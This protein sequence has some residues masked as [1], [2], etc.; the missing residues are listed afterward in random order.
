MHLYTCHHLSETVLLISFGHEIS[1]PLHEQVMQAKSKIESNPFNGLIETV[2]AYNCLAVHYNPLQVAKKN[3]SN[4]ETVEQIINTILETGSP[5]FSQKKP[6]ILTIPVCYDESLG[7][8]LNELSE[9]LQ[10]SIE[11]IIHLHSRKIY[12]VF[13]T[14]FTPGFPYM[15]I[16][17][18]RLITKRKSSPRLKVEVG[19]VAIAG[20]QTGIYPFPTPGGWNIIG[21]TP[22][23]L[24]NRSKP[25][26]FF[27]KAGDQVRFTPITKEE[28]EQ[29]IDTT[30]IEKKEPINYSSLAT[31]KQEAAKQII[32]LEQCGFLTT[33]QDAGRNGHLQYGVPQTGAMD[34]YS[35]KLAN[36]LTGNQENT[37]VLEIT[38]S[39]HLFRIMKDCLVAF[40]GGGLQPI[41]DG[42]ELPLFE[43]LFI[44]EGT[45]IELKKQIPGFRLYMAVGGGFEAERFLGS[46]STD[47][48]ISAGGF[49]GRA[50]KKEDVLCQQHALNAAQTHLQTV[51]NN[52]VR[53][54]LNINTGFVTAIKIRVVKGIE[55]HYLTEDAQQMIW[56]QPFTISPQS[57]RMGYRLKANSLTARQSCDIISSPVTTGTVQLTSSGELIVL[58]ADAQ[59]VGGYPRVLQVINADLRILAQ[60][61]PGD[62]ITFEEVSLK[63]AEEILVQQVKYINDFQKTTQQF[64]AG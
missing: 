27:L 55:W 17:D 58:M 3:N 13:M 16:V 2:P 52:R 32:Q 4:P 33:I 38:Q 64:Y 19:A 12:K 21:R 59:T 60:K 36:L 45:T 42:N 43:C 40:T 30:A 9:T 25:D 14:G 26:P 22:L 39:P 44:K 8:D 18:E 50:L 41:A 61:K 57:S 29:Y 62:T 31:K 1:L 20:S 6:S 46:C 53:L 24:F 56:D 5:V 28:F 48:T 7:I 11:E 63:E 10:L 51:L 35:M 37:P 15:G 23:L 54:Q 34:S 49:K 47:I